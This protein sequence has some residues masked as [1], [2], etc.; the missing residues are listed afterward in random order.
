MSEPR[1]TEHDI[2]PVFLQRWSANVTVQGGPHI[3]IGNWSFRC[4]GYG[5]MLRFRLAVH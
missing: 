2:H 3:V 4:R 5:L 1:T